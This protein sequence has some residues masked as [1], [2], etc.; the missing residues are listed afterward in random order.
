MMIDRPTL[1]ECWCGRRTLEP[2]LRAALLLAVAH[3]HDAPRQLHANPPRPRRRQLQA[4]RRRSA[5][6]RSLTAWQAGVI[7]ET[8]VSG[9]LQVAAR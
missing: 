7:P 2:T 9:R 3:E 1:L 6:A 4:A 5:R 8:Y